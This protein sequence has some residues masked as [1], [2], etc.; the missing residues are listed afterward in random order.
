A[1]P[2]AAANPH[3]ER[4]ARPSDRRSTWSRRRACRANSPRQRRRGAASGRFRDRRLDAPTLAEVRAR[5]AGVRLLSAGARGRG[6]GGR[7]RRPPSKRRRPRPPAA[8]RA[9]RKPG[10]RA[11]APRAARTA[12]NECPPSA[13]PYRSGRVPHQECEARVASI[14]SS[15]R[16]WRRKRLTTENRR[17]GG[18]TP[19]P[20]HPADAERLLRRRQRPPGRFD[21]NELKER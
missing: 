7:G 17:N 11:T 19:L 5:P 8:A 10:I 12:A 3:R 18:P 16:S 4:L 14:T 20:P 1:L 13:A 6:V 15:Q 21:R 9:I 2:E